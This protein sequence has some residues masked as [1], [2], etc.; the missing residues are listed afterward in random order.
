M[1]IGAERAGSGPQEIVLSGGS[2]SVLKKRALPANKKAGEKGVRISPSDDAD[3][4]HINYGTFH[5]AKGLEFRAVALLGCEK[6]KLP[7]KR[8]IGKMQSEGAREEMKARERHLF[9]VGCTR[10]REHLLVTGVGEM[11]EFLKGDD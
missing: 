4:S 3:T 1:D 8:L 7:H 11:T 2:N 9:Y 10:P 6:G 5:S